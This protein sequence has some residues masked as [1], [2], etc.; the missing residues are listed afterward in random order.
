M[1]WAEDGK[2]AISIFESRNDID[3]VLM[4]IEM[5]IIDG[6]EATAR[7]KLLIELRL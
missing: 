5:P 4:Y 2:K 1:V 7:I 6:Y 3:L